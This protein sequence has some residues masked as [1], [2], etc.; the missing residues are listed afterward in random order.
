MSL[1]TFRPLDP[2][3]LAKILISLVH[4][5][6]NGDCLLKFFLMGVVTFG[7]DGTL[8]RASRR[9]QKHVPPLLAVHMGTVGFLTSVDHLDHLRASIREVLSGVLHT[10]SISPFHQLFT[11][12]GH[13]SVTPRLRLLSEIHSESGEL[14]QSY[15]ALNEISLHRYALARYKKAQKEELYHLYLCEELT[16]QV[17]LIL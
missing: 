5:I 4:Q 15:H 9:F 8:L 10:S 1:K 14:L 13:F 3:I 17:D 2:R 12:E 7:G 6:T 11:K 16:Q